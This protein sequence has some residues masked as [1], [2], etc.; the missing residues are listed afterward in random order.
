M[1]CHQKILHLMVF[2]VSLHQLNLP[3]F[4]VQPEHKGATAKIGLNGLYRPEPAPF[5]LPQSAI[6]ERKLYFT[7]KTAIFYG[8]ISYVID[9]YC[10]FIGRK[11]KAFRSSPVLTS[12]TYYVIPTTTALRYSKNAP[13]PTPRKVTK[14]EMCS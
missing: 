2:T 1:I 11:I 4:E 10:I 7:V 8:H 14:P 13:F 6:P 3:S 12:C 5:I 9:I